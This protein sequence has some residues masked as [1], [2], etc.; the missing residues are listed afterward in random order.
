[1][2]DKFA[3]DAVI[4]GAGPNGLAAAIRIAQAKLSVLLLEAHDVIGGGTCSR[5][6]TLPGFTHDLCSAIHP[7]AVGSPFFRKLPLEKFGLTWIQPEFP[8]AHPFDDGTAAV[9]RRSVAE[10]ALGLGPDQANYERW[11]TPLVTHWENLASEFLQSPLHIPRHP[12]Q[13]ARF[14]FYAL[15]SA[16]RCAKNLF[17]S[18][19]ARALFGGLAAHSFLP[20]EQIPS[21]AFAL[22]LGLMGHAVGWPLARGGSQQIANALAAY[23]RNLGGEIQVNSPVESL[24]TL[25]PARVILLDVTPKQMLHLA[26]STVPPFYRQQLERYRYGPGVFKV[27]FA[28]SGPIPW[29]AQDCRLAGTVHLGGLLSEIVNSER[30]VANGICPLRPFVLLAQPTLFDPTRAPTGKQIAWAYCHVP[31]GSSVDMTS[32]IE[33]QIERF[34][35]GFLE[36]VLARHTMDCRAMEQRNPNLVGGDINGGAANLRQILARPTLHPCPYR[37]ALPGVYLCSSSTPPGG[38]V[39]GMCGFHAAEAALRDWFPGKTQAN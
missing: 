29:K 22:V 34:A 13:L 5:E 15:R 32:Q 7:M 37:T 11:M 20:L 8:L 16:D 35:P 10:T 31:N 30:E 39:H 28:L 21:A 26:G 1:M 36:R 25:P 6:I 38:G 12:L 19:A 18:E 24:S 2:P 14:G 4:V 3:Y 33:A 23:L 9:L 17:T 27:D